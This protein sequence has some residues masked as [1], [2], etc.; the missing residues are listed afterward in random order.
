[1][2]KKCGRSNEDIKV[3]RY[4][5]PGQNENIFQSVKGSYH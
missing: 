4:V 3:K 1:M 2:G 5:S